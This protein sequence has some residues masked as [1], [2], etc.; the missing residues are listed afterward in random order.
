[1]KISVIDTGKFKLD[2]GA[3][4][5]VVPKTIWSKTNPADEN[6]MCSWSMRCLLLEFDD[7]KILIDTGIGNKQSEKFFQHFY[8]HGTDNLINS[9]KKINVSPD[10][11][12]HVFFTHLHFDHCGGAVIKH[13]DQYDLLFKNS[14]HLTNEIHWKLANNPN[15]REKASFLKENF[16][17]I[18]EKNKLKFINEGDLYSNM[19]VRFFHGHTAGQ[20]IPII[21]TNHGTL[22]FM[23]DLLPSIGHIPLP[24]IMGYDT[25][26]LITLN[27]K[28]MFLEEAVNNNYILFLEHDYH[29]ECCTLKRTEKGVRL[30]KYGSLKELL[31]NGIT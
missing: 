28:K 20:M 29:Y 12:T 14:I 11:I 21:N 19:K 31:F 17:I 22:V 18:K 27:E 5:G 1:M 9:L 6:N 23:A 25:Q 15:G 16:M 7:K 4:F 10:Q 2:G 24:Y 30:D 8:L 3:M 26:P 13:N